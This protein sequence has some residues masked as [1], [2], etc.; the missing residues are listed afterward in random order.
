MITSMTKKATLP[1]LII[2]ILV[3]AI[4][5]IT[6]SILTT[7]QKAGRLSGVEKEVQTLE[8]EKKRLESEKDYRSSTEYV[9]SEARNKLQMAKDSEHVVVLPQNN[10]QNNKQTGLS[11]TNQEASN[12]KKWLNYWL[13]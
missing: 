2:I 9:E 12:F 5:F 7:G 6:R 11:Q 3:V 4:V 8:E 10:E 13:N 1:V